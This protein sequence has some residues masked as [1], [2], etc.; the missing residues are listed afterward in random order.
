[1]IHRKEEMKR[2][3]IIGYGSLAQGLTPLLRKHYPEYEISVITADTGGYI[4]ANEYG[5]KHQVKPLTPDNYRLILPLV[6]SAGDI[7]LNL[8]VNVSSLALIEWCQ[9][10]GVTYL[11]TCVEPWDGGYVK[12]SVKESTN[13]HLREEALKLR[14]PNTPTAVIAHGANPGLVSYF[15]KEG[16]K[17]LTKDRGLTHSE[18]YGEMARDLG[19]QTIQIAERDTQDMSIQDAG[20]LFINTWSVCGLMSEAA[21]F[22]EMSLG[23]HENYIPDSVIIQENAIGRSAMLADYGH[24]TFVKSWVPS[25]GPQIAYL[26]THHE[27]FSIADFLTT[28]ETPGNKE[29]RPSVYYAYRPNDH[30]VSCLQKMS[31][32]HRYNQQ[33]VQKMIMVDEIDTGFDELGVLFCY[34]GGAYWYG[35]HLTIDETRELAP[36]NNATT[37]QVNATILGAI[38]W[39][40]ENPMRGVVEA[41]EVDYDTVMDIALPYLGT[42]RGVHTRWSPSEDSLNLTHSVFISCA[43]M[44]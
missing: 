3:V 44:D 19:I 14:K 18:N 25:G 10:Q 40:E 9:E 41:E 13:H 15:V 4:I 23:T 21:Q 2:F 8:S 42:V 37:L 17:N 11:D 12:R 34:K 26:I 27:A 38:R 35:S 16:L 7:M 30:T 33:T 32:D 24:S 5:V 1:M 20:D 22:S 29:Y 36:Y 31:S 39:I 28:P 43:V 6:T